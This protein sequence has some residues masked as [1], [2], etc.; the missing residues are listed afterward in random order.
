MRGLM[1]LFIVDIA[2]DCHLVKGVDSRFG[3]S[4]ELYICPVLIRP[5]LFLTG[6]LHA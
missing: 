2:V 5:K 1:F 3:K 4:P 6:N